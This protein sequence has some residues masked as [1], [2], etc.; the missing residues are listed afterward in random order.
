MGDNFLKRQTENFKK[1]RDLAIDELSRPT[2]WNQPEFVQTIFTA[3]PGEN[4]QLESGEI[5]TVYPSDDGATA[6]LARGHRSVGHIGGDGGKSLLGALNQTGTGGMAQIKVTEVSGL[7]GV[8]KAV[9][10]KD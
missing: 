8:G 6:T 9:I 2:L 5:L 4:C 10:V 7:S 3:F 1:G